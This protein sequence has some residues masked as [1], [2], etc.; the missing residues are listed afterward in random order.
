MFQVVLHAVK[1]ISN[2]LI[3]TVLSN[4][5]QSLYFRSTISDLGITGGPGQYFYTA[6]Q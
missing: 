5:D 6:A 3:I 2:I 4:A 1:W